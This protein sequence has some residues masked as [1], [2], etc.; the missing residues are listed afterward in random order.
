MLPSQVDD[1]TLINE[2]KKNHT[3]S[4]ISEAINRWSGA[5]V[6]ICQNYTY[7]PKFEMDE[8][9]QNKDTNIYNFVL[10]Y[11]EKKGM[12]PSTFISQMAKYQCQSKVLKYQ[13]PEQINDEL[14]SGEE[15]TFSEN[16]TV[17]NRALARVGNPRFTEII[18][19]RYFGNDV[20]PWK[21]IGSVMGL[22]HEW[23]RQCYLNEISR[24]KKFIESEMKVG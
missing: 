2:I 21:K 12:R 23:V 17:I 8:I 16:K 15:I 18:H 20:M 7:V 6:S 5:Y 1:L 19:L 24:F 3:N 22:S 14:I 9:I 10:S 13:E 11:D 4:Y